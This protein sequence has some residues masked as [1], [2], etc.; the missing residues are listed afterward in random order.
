MH[1]TL[2]I[3][4]I[5]VINVYDK[6]SIGQEDMKQKLNFSLPRASPKVNTFN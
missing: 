1:C 3:L 6:N 4:N 2:C 5:K